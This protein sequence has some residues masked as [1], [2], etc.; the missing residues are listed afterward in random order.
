MGS[1]HFS[2]VLESHA[3]GQELDRECQCP[4][5][6]KLLL[7]LQQKLEMHL[8]ESLDVVLLELL[9]ELVDDPL[10]W[11][12]VVLLVLTSTSIKKLIIISESFITNK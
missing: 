2:S 3:H 10:V 9:H 6:D 7:F 1:D 4:G 12:F 5:S 11:Y 8:V